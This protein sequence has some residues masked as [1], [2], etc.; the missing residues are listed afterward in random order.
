LVDF[1]VL[2]DKVWPTDLVVEYMTNVE[3][4]ELLVEFEV[5]D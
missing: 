2:E 4:E 1:L 5:I 3:V